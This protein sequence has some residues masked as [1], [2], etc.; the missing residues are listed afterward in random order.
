[1]FAIASYTALAFVA[2]SSVSG[3]A[4]PRA[5]PPAGWASDYLEPYATYNTRYLALGCQNKHDSP[6]FDQ[7]CHPLLATEK[8]ETARPPQCNPSVPTTPSAPAVKPTSTVT[9]PDDDDDDLED[10]DNDEDNG[11][12]TPSV[13]VPAPTPSPTK[14]ATFFYQ[15]G[16]AGACGT[17][18]G[19]GDMI[20]AIDGN[21]YGNLGAKSSLCG[22]RVKVT[23]PANK[24]SVV[25]TI[26]DACP[27]CKNGNSIDLSEGAFKQIATLDQGMVGITWTF[28]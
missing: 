1:M 24:K 4:I 26:A 7:C 13:P 22:K 19:D 9:T 11:D 25:V 12:D 17:V 5:T 10:C 16:V 18:H 23:N 3:L 2:I 6:F 15:N 20:A 27:T 28:I 14:A 8:L 21:R